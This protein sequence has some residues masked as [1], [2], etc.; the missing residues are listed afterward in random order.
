MN[1]LKEKKIVKKP[2][3]REV[4][5]AHTEDYMGK[6]LIIQPGEQVS[7]HYHKDKEETMYVM[8]GIMEVYTVGQEGTIVL[9]EEVCTEGVFHVEPGQYHS[10]KCISNPQPVYLFEVSTPHP[11]DSI[12]IKD[13]YG[14]DDESS[15]S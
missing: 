3:G 5:F 15:N 12:R 7:L 10:M 9:Q 13:F 6:L 14:R 2:W 8:F 4:W 1:K 11:D